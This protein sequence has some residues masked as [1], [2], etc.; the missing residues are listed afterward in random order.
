MYYASIVAR[1]IERGIC[2]PPPLFAGDTLPST[3]SLAHGVNRR[4]TQR[5]RGT[6]YLSHTFGNAFAGTSKHLPH[7]VGGSSAARTIRADDLPHIVSRAS[8]S[9]SNDLPHTIYS[10]TTSGWRTNHLT[11]AI[12]GA[13]TRIRKIHKQWRCYCKHS[14]EKIFHFD[15]S[16]R[17]E[18]TSSRGGVT[19]IHI[20]DASCALQTG[21]ST[22]PKSMSR[23]H[24]TF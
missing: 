10:S 21:W 18:V 14:E 1:T 4:T 7:A 5:Q 2:F 12:F 9:A 17:L 13:S 22:L 11:Q 19:I 16:D 8:T 6:P 23:L 24:Y 3:N 15:C 20:F